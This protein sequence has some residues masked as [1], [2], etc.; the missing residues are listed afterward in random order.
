MDGTGPATA[1]NRGVSGDIGQNS[2]C[3]AKNF[4]IAMALPRIIV[5]KAHQMN[6]VPEYCCIGPEWITRPAIHAIAA[7]IH[8]PT[9]MYRRPCW[10]PDP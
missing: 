1:V 5:A 3:V 10:R 6:T 7:Q 2:A 8:A 9:A 4:T